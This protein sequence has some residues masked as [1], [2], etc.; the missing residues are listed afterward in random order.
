MTDFAT[1]YAGYR[2]ANTRRGDTLQRIA[3]RELGDA[4]SWAKL[5]WFNDLIPPFITDDSDLAGDRVVLAGQPIKIPSSTAESEPATDGATNVL[6]T[7]CSLVSGRL[8]VD[9]NGDLAVLSGRDNLKQ[10]LRHLVK[11]DPGEL[12]F[13]PDYGCKIQRRVG[14]K[15]NA[16][17]LLRGQMDVQD[18]LVSEARLKTIDSITVGSSG[19]ALV[20]VAQ[21]TP[22]SGDSVTIEATV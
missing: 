18:A 14:A 16:V 5:V 8:S 15:N 1:T 2:Y 21:V 22:I 19:D 10:A 7:D 20:V 6:L 9:S 17:T 4:A 13:H 3:L 11:T 12:L